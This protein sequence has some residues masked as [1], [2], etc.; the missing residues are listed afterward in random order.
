MTSSLPAARSLLTPTIP[1]ATRVVE[2]DAGPARLLV[3]PTATRDVVSFRASFEVAPDLGTSDDVAL[4]LVA[5]VLDKGTTSRDRHAFADALDGRGAT[6]S[7]YSDSLR[8]GFAGRA[9]RADLPDVLALAAEALREPAARR[10]R[11]PQG[12]R[13]DR[14]RRPPLARVDGPA[15]R[16]GDGA[17]ARPRRTTR[18]TSTRPRTRRRARPRSRPRASARR[19]SGTSGRTASCSPS[20]A[21]PI[22]ARSRRRSPTA[23][24]GGPPHGRDARFAP[25]AA[26]VVPGREDIPIADRTSLD[27][28]LAHAVALRRDAPDFLAAY[29]AVYALG[30]N[31]SSRLMQTIRDEQGLTYGIGA[32]FGGVD[33]EHDGGFGVSVTL[34]Q[35]SL[36]RGIVAVREEVERFVAE[37][38]PAD[39]L[40]QVQTTLAG[41]H[42]VAMATTG[43][44]AARLLVN[45]ERGF[46]VGY[47]D[48]YPDLVRAV[49]PAEATAALRRHVRP[50]DLHVTVAG[51]FPSRS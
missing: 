2:V 15:G 8:L 40:E 35:E 16:R 37:G 11:D 3:L 34:S 43:G 38:V 39:A 13:P 36:E 46:D 17:P 50:A 30:G 19:G 22:R 4:G 41:L 18:T 31:F 26:P 49:T 51:T 20:S 23:S 44:L 47:L 5:D 33:V 1:L 25:A 10:R 24:A 7:F 42:V 27:V 28:R 12:G 9:L 48:R 45:A 6:L 32:A 21:T 29:A 14:R